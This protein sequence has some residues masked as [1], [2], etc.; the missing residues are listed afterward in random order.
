MLTHLT[1]AKYPSCN[2]SRWWRSHQ[3]GQ[4]LCQLTLDKQRNWSPNKHG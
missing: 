4:N 3:S 2:L 1:S